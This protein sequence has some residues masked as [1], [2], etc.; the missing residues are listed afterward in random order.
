M[1]HSALSALAE[2]TEGLRRQAAPLQ[3][4][5]KAFHQL[6]PVRTRFALRA[7]FP[8]LKYVCA[9]LCLCAFPPVMGARLSRCNCYGVCVCVHVCLLLLSYHDQDVSLAR[10]EVETLRHRLAGLEEEMERQILRMQEPHVH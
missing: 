2:E 4:K 10:L 9:S 6:P 5:L 1:T 7:S 3:A 8:P